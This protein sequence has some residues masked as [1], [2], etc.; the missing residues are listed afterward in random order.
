MLGLR[1]SIAQII[2]ARITSHIVGMEAGE[3]KMGS[4]GD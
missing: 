4:Y 3:K 2:S 1:I